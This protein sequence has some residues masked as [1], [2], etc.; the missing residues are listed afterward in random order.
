MGFAECILSQ[1]LGCVNEHSYRTTDLGG[2][3]VSRFASQES[4]AAKFAFNNKPPELA[5]LQRA[6]GKHDMQACGGRIDALLALG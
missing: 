3:A 5:R 6:N 1:V 2:R 4:V